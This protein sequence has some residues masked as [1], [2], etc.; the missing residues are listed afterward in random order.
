ML[1]FRAYSATPMRGQN[2]DVS[3]LKDCKIGRP[4]A[5]KLLTIRWALN[6]GNCG[7]DWP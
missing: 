5:E 2:K 3:H 1:P 7:H 6:I 4:S